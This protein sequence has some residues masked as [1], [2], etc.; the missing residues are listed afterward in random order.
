[1][2]KRTRKSHFLQIHI[3]TICIHLL[4]FKRN[5]N[6]IFYQLNSKY[7]NNLSIPHCLAKGNFLKESKLI[8]SN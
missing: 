3:H 5:L 7:F 8:N 4:L 6:K 2:K 1:M